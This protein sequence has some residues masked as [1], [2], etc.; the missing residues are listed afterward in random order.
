VDPYENHFCRW[1]RGDLGNRDVSSL[2]E[3]RAD[4]FARALLV[5][6]DIIS[7]AWREMEPEKVADVLGVPPALVWRR[8]G[9]IGAARGDI[10]PPPA[11][12]T[13]GRE[14][15]G[16][17]PTDLPERFVN[18]AIAAYASRALEI[19]ELSRFLRVSPKRVAQFIEWSRIPRDRK[20]EDAAV[21]AAE[22]DESDGADE[23][24]RGGV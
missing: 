2:V 20:E 1:R 3:M 10:P 19:G 12:V 5:P 23:D 17:P 6:D 8:L 16:I 15:E 24:D 14:V 18:L 11:P 13:V 9:D 22:S 21:R 7:G 4:R